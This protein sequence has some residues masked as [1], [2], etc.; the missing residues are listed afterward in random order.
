M[1]NKD[2]YIHM[3]QLERFK[4]RLTRYYLA[5]ALFNLLFILAIL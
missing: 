2:V 4:R 1:Y 3:S 5:V